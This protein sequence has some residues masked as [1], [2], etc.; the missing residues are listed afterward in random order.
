MNDGRVD[1]RGRLHRAI[2]KVQPA[3]VISIMPCTVQRRSGCG[4]A[5]ADLAVLVFGDVGVSVDLPVLFNLVGANESVL[6]AVEEML[7]RVRHLH[8][9]AD[10]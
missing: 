9:F 4:R 7:R 2:R 1:R 3:Q 8:R 10:G 6:C 5:D